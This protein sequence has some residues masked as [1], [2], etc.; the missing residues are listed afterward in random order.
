MSGITVDQVQG[1]TFK[2]VMTGEYLQLMDRNPMNSVLT[3]GVSETFEGANFFIDYTELSSLPSGS[4][5]P[6]GTPLS[7]AE[8]N[9]FMRAFAGGVLVIPRSIPM[10]TSVET[11]NRWSVVAEWNKVA[12]PLAN[13]APALIAMGRM[14]P[15]GGTPSHPYTQDLA[16]AINQAYIPTSQKEI[17][18]QINSL[19][20][21][22]ALD[23]NTRVQTLHAS[24]GTLE[25]F[26]KW[27]QGALSL[28][29]PSVK[30]ILD[31][32]TRATKFGGG[33][34]TGT[35]MTFSFVTYIAS[36]VRAFADCYG[37]NMHFAYDW[38]VKQNSLPIHAI[39]ISAIPYTKIGTNLMH[40]AM[41]TEITMGKEPKYLNGPQNLDAWRVVPGGEWLIQN[42]NATEGQVKIS[43]PRPVSVARV[44]V[45]LYQDFTVSLWGE[46]NLISRT[47]AEV[48]G[49][50]VSTTEPSGRTAQLYMQSDGSV[51]PMPFA[52][53]ILTGT[54]STWRCPKQK[55]PSLLSWWM[56]P[57]LGHAK[58]EMAPS[59]PP[60]LNQEEF[61]PGGFYGPIVRTQ[62]QQKPAYLVASA[63]GNVGLIAETDVNTVLKTS[64]Y[65]WWMRPESTA[66]IDGSTYKGYY[67][68]LTP[69]PSANN[70]VYINQ[71]F[72]YTPWM[73]L[74]LNDNASAR[75]NRAQG[76][77]TKAD[78][79]MLL[80]W[81]M[82]GTAYTS[83]LS[84]KSLCQ[85]D[86]ATERQLFRW[87]EGS[88]QFPGTRILECKAFPFRKPD[89]PASLSFPDAQLVWDSA[90]P[91]TDLKCDAFYISLAQG[92]STANPTGIAYPPIH[93]RE[94]KIFA[95]SSRA[96]GYTGKIGVGTDAATGKKKWFWPY[97]IDGLGS[98]FSN[99]VSV[100]TDHDPNTN[101]ADSTYPASF[102]DVG[103]SE[104][105]RLGGIN[106]KLLACYTADDDE[107]DVDVIAAAAQAAGALAAAAAP[108]QDAGM[109]AAAGV[110][111]GAAGA[112]GMDAAAG[113]EAAPNYAG[114]GGGGAG[115]LAP[116]APADMAAAVA[117]TA[118]TNT[119][120]TVAAAAERNAMI[121]AVAGEGVGAGPPQGQPAQDLLLAQAADVSSAGGHYAGSNSSS[122]DY[123]G[124]NPVNP[125]G[126]APLPALAGGGQQ[127][128]IID[129]IVTFFS[130]GLGSMFGSLPDIAHPGGGAAAAA[131]P[132]APVRPDAAWSMLLQLA[133]FAGMM[134]NAHNVALGILHQ[135]QETMNQVVDRIMQQH[136]EYTPEQAHALLGEMQNA[137]P[138]TN[139][140]IPAPAGTTGAAITAP[141]L[142]AAGLPLPHAGGVGGD[143]GG[144][145]AANPVGHALYEY[146]EDVQEAVGLNINHAADQAV[147][148]TGILSFLLCAI[149]LAARA[150]HNAG[151]LN[152][153]NAP[154]GPTV[155]AAVQQTEDAVRTNHALPFP[156]ETIGKFI[157]GEPQDI[158]EPL[159]Y[160]IA[161]DE[162]HR[163]ER[164]GVAPGATE[165]HPHLFR[166]PELMDPE[167]F[168]AYD[169][170]LSRN[171]P[172]LITPQDMHDALDGVPLSGLL[173]QGTG[174]FQTHPSAGQ[175]PV[176]AQDGPIWTAVH[177]FMGI[178]Q[179]INN[180][181]H[182]FLGTP[183]AASGG[184]SGGSGGTMLA[185]LLGPIASI[186]QSY[187][188]DSNP[189]Q[190]GQGQVPLQ[191]Q[192]WYGMINPA[193]LAGM[194]GAVAPGYGGGQAMQPP[195]FMALMAG[196]WHTFIT[197]TLFTIYQIPEADF[198]AATD[199]AHG[200]MAPNG[201]D[202]L[203]G[204]I[205]FMLAL[206]AG[207]APPYQGM[208]GA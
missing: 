139:F 117:A 141:G 94:L 199:P 156:A 138:F 23:Y 119:T 8:Y 53:D 181:A 162:D 84:T 145:G 51:S 158:F 60:W 105:R 198:F 112:A 35:M 171:G 5:A 104:L 101:K 46:E 36:L 120:A 92:M 9:S 20:N 142:A 202:S 206:A 44:V 125:Q 126:V 195:N 91:A 59:P 79:K 137:L 99:C 108:Q 57:Q 204:L 13:T 144:A 180:N 18:A 34:S 155:I 85:V 174:T 86:D 143:T 15:A 22:V 37:S 123:A 163:T 146:F 2:N 153:P 115:V 83:P 194:P 24:N 97:R 157:S 175:T 41:I 42:P 52:E 185:D 38:S 4:C 133:V 109:P 197:T 78:P 151:G 167:A 114:L 131:V 177:E 159:T 74:T 71:P 33:P 62:E 75:P 7:I 98:A 196:T 88:P 140:L 1:Y 73:A 178:A 61:S 173:Q 190:A 100:H 124:P 6:C 90:G 111:L 45:R 172:Q 187:N 205:T 39:P 29:D 54:T 149:S 135:I 148:W 50:A 183:P 64:G 189:Y 129:T 58:G 127:Q 47:A 16:G 147:V 28:T 164:L 193:F 207:I 188:T 65:H 81:V 63:G 95:G 113:I 43:W 11:S 30:F 154:N 3:T 17:M 201:A 110:A 106:S 116:P 76:D 89:E 14:Y 166:F 68:L 87:V 208:S 10:S 77:L 96:L 130:V 128:N 82:P 107:E 67:R 19:E 136:P 80:P 165:E 200:A 150:A 191:N 161:S 186:F 176:V 121:A 69:V 134:A 32:K 184:G 72:T 56:F 182:G 179:W 160:L 102:V 93:V 66:P 49:A 170:E 48:G 40:S 203:N 21:A 192:A 118:P 27:S 70:C 169:E 168:L 55:D 152:G 122:D 31:A 132:G 103:R 12:A 26:E 25:L